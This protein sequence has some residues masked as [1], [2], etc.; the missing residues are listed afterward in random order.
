MA[1]TQ[2]KT[3]A[4]KKSASPKPAASKTTAAKGGAKSPSSRSA[5]TRAKKPPQKKPVRREVWGIVLFVLALCTAVSYVGISAIFID[6][7]A[8][9]LK[10]LVGYGYF[11]AA[12][13][14]VFAGAILLFHHGRPVR[15]RTA[16]ALQPR[17][18]AEFARL[19]A[20]CKE[21]YDELNA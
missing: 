8:A 21:L 17:I 19:T 9:L 5:S 14:M 20:F 3:T 7:L 16:C 12:P 4:E 1:S 15:L 11:L 18:E 2:K 10:G 13:A 6:W